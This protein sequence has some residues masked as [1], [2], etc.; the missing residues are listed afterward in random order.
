MGRL[1]QLVE[2]VSE[3]GD[4]LRLAD[5]DERL[6]GTRN[7]CVDIYDPPDGPRRGNQRQEVFLVGCS[8]NHDIIGDVLKRFDNS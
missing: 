4:L 7:A 6:S 5:F 2:V 8:N 3:D 1:E